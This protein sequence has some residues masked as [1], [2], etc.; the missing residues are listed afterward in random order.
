MLY[1]H[2]FGSAETMDRARY[3]LTWHGF[4]VSEPATPADPYGRPAPLCLVVR[5]DASA[6]SAVQV[7]IDSIE[8]IDASAGSLLP[9]AGS[10]RRWIADQPSA[11]GQP[12]PGP[13]GSQIHWDSHHDFASDPGSSKVSEY[14]FS[15]W[16]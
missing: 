3:W 2:S 10:T 7:L 14:M 15:R 16:E 5:I 13:H 12:A 1:A 11:A 9:G 6:R 4:A 8:Q